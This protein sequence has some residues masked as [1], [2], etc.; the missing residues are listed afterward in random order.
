MRIAAGLS[1]FAL[2]ACGSTGQ[3]AYPD[4][5]PPPAPYGTAALPPVDDLLDPPPQAAPERV[6]APVDSADERREDP[7]DLPPT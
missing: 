4:G 7:F 6:D 3:L 2:T 1:L 5:G